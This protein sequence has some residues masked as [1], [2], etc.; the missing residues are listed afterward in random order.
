M[1]R[2]LTRIYTALMSE[3]HPFN[4]SSDKFAYAQAFS[5]ST[6]RRADR[7]PR[8][9]HLRVPLLHIARKRSVSR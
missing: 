4:A 6:V 9:R 1:N 8:V 3:R 7:L 2:D 5:A